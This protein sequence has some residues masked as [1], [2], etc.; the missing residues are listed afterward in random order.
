[1]LPRTPV[2]TGV[3]AIQVVKSV[4]SDNA[5]QAAKEVFG[6]DRFGRYLQ[7]AEGNVATAVRLAKWNQ[8]FAGLLHTQIGY[9]ELA[10]RNAIDAQLRKL[11]LGET[12]TEDWTQAGHVPHLVHS[13]ISGIINEA[14]SRAAADASERLRRNSHRNDS[15]VTHADVLSQLMWGTWVKLIGRS[16]TSERT[17]VQQELWRSCLC[18]AFKHGPSGEAGRTKLSKQLF[19]LR[20]VRNSEAH[21]DTLYNA[22][23]NI[24][25]IINTCYSV[26]NSIDPNLTH[27]WIAPELLRHKAREL[28]ELMSST[29]NNS[30]K[31]FEANFD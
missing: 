13:L 27:G 18:S 8:E 20:S 3:L 25:R 14:R 12:R 23:Q 9:V 7:D 29:E 17:L 16:Y 2:S 10:T 5:E 11:S 21:F 15:E 28:K 24:N 22:A 4:L 6:E 19:Y 31:Q 1:M 30:P 26:L